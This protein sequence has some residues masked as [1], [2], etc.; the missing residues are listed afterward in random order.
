MLFQ[1]WGLLIYHITILTS[2]H[3]APNFFIFG[4][5]RVLAG[6]VAPLAILLGSVD[7]SFSATVAPHRAFYEMQLGSADLNSNVQAVIGRSAF[8]LGRDCSGWQSNEDYVVEFEGKEGNTNRII[9]RFESWESDAGDMYS[10]EISEQSSFQIKKDFNGYA[11]VTSK[12]G[13]AYFS[14]EGDAP[15]KLPPDTYFPMRHLNAIIDSAEEGKTILSA[16]VFTGADPDD[17]LLA[18]NTVIGNWK[19]EAPASRL[20]EFGQKGYWPVQTAYFKPAA[21]AAEPEYE[22]NYSMQSNGVVRRYV[23]DYGDF[24]IIAKLKKLE[25]IATPNCP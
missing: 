6:L 12:A 14:I 17:A 11:N 19:I 25:A 15:M 2:I 9:S 21:K 3:M 5:R 20:G 4:A 24:T 7:P 1:K 18:T 23:I 8:T 10:F 22:I 16:S 13:N